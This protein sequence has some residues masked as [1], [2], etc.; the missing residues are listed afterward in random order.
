[1]QTY[2]FICQ[3]C[4]EP[5]SRY[6]TFE[7]LFEARPVCDQC[8]TKLLPNIDYIRKLPF[9]T[10]RDVLIDPMLAAS[11]LQRPIFTFGEEVDESQ[12]IKYTTMMASGQWLDAKMGCGGEQAPIVIM[13]GSLMLGFQRL[14]A[15]YDSN[16][17]FTNTV[18]EV[19]DG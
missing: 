10:M 1:M 13:N 7:S 12:V 2:E 11:W 17:A 3:G 6:L 15:C 16:T 9:A 4:D 18:I 14:L 5:Q 19:N 8:G